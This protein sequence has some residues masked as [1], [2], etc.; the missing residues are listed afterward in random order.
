MQTELSAYMNFGMPYAVIFKKCQPL[1]FRQE[2]YIIS[3]CLVTN[4]SFLVS[5]FRCLETKI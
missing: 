3:G 5:V 2:P 4:D 1:H